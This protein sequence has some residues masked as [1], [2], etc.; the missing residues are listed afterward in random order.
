MTTKL[1]EITKLLDGLQSSLNEAI[2]NSFKEVFVFISWE[3]R[4]P[5]G[6]DLRTMLL[7]Y[8]MNVDR[9]YQSFHRSPEGRNDIILVSTPGCT[10]RLDGWKWYQTEG[11]TGEISLYRFN[12]S[13]NKHYAAWKNDP[14]T[15]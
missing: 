8:G 7:T 6:D 12:E 9:I 5:K 11:L 3:G 4:R 14:P 1:D 10:K 15:D 2:G 13:L